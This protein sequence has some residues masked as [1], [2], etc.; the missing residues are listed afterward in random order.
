[1]MTIES[2]T[3]G[4][5]R[6]E[7][8]GWRSI[9]RHLYVAQLSHLFCSRVRQMFREKNGGACR[10]EG[11]AVSRVGNNP[12]LSNGAHLVSGPLAAPD[13]MPVHWVPKVEL[14]AVRSAWTWLGGRV[15]WRK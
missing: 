3:D 15:S 8:R 10:F 5:S 11:F 14:G 9:H 12:D 2:T 13:P 4:E 7:V 1:M 6:F